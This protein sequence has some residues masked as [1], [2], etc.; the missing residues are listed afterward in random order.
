MRNLFVRLLVLSSMLSLSL[1]ARANTVL[2]KDGAT[3]EG[4]IN[5]VEEG[6]IYITVDGE[7]KIV[8]MLLVQ[9]MNF[10]TPH[11]LAKVGNATVEYFLKEF[12]AQQIVRSMKDIDTTAAELRRK[13]E[14]IR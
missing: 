8:N 5:K 13:L 4:V 6:K 12:E 7:E 3:M 1:P 10:N 11:L 2:F 14:Q 9:S